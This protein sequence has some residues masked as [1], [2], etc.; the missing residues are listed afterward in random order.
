MSAA[1]PT[2]L[3]V[4]DEERILRSLRMLFRGRCEVL[5]T[6]SGK[7]AIEWVRQRPVHVVISDQRMPEVSGVA[8]L[9]A[10]AQHSPATMRIR[11]EPVRTRSA[12]RSAQSQTTTHATTRRS[13]VWT[14]T[15]A[16]SAGVAATM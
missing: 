6:T 7:E 4:D 13:G 15:V 2:V 5:A 1:L 9:R 3:F 12:Q 10:V 16:I 14:D 8:V 11:S